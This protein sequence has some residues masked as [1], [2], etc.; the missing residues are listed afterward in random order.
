MTQKIEKIRLDQLL[1]KKNSFPPEK[2]PEASLF[3]EKC[4]CK[5]PLPIN[6]VAYFL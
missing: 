6:P 1:V 5:M 4:E 2:K 3:Q